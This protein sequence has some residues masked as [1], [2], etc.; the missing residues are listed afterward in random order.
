MKPNDLENYLELL[1]AFDT[2]MLVTRRGKENRSR[3][4]SIA[5]RSE[6]GRIWF[7]T[8]IESGKLDELTDEPQ[9]NLSMQA[10]S[11]F[12]SI[13]GAVK[14][15]RDPE[16]VQQLWSAAFSAWFPEGKDDPSIIVLEI[17]PTY[18]EYWDNSGVEGVKALFELG[19]SAITRDA[20]ENDDS[21][22]EKLDFPD[23]Q[24]GAPKDAR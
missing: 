5:D 9:I 23:E 15:T 2:A 21:V 8:S 16:K 20:A 19:K 14:A 17:V 10:D 11:K 6:D 1:G 7:L 13:S 3:P 24:L 12:L 18:A 4:M 22:H